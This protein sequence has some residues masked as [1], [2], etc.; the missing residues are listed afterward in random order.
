MEEALEDKRK[1][2]DKAARGLKIAPAASHIRACHHEPI[3]KKKASEAKVTQQA[4]NFNFGNGEYSQIHL[5]RLVAA[6]SYMY[7]FSI[8]VPRWR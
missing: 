4:T 3:K 2:G 1:H 6:A 5:T 7:A 8:L